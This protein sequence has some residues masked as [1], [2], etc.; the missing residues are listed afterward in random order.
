MRLLIQNEWVVGPANTTKQS[1]YA[2]LNQLVANSA[3]GADSADLVVLFLG[4]DYVKRRAGLGG[5]IQFEIK[6]MVEISGFFN[7]AVAYVWTPLGWCFLSPTPTWIRRPLRRVLAWL[8]ALGVACFV[9]WSQWWVH[10]VN[11]RYL[12]H[13]PVTYDYP[14]GYAQLL[15]RWDHQPIDITYL[16]I[17]SDGRYSLIGVVLDASTVLT[18]GNEAT[19]QYAHRQGKQ[20]VKVTGKL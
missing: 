18:I 12:I 7:S 10:T 3:G 6:K 13:T 1:L 8:L 2:L 11:S 20:W 17:D 16:S 19:A 14:V 15:E 4:S 9:G 5:V